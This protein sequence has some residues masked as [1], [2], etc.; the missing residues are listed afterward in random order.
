MLRPPYPRVDITAVA[1]DEVGCGHIVALGR[2]QAAVG[3]RRQ[4]DVCIEPNLMRG[5]A[6]QHRPTAR[7]PDIADQEPRPIRY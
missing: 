4:P 2:R 3:H 5:V 1:V 6:G 7:L